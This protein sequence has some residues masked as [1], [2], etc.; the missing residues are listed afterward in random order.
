MAQMLSNKEIAYKTEV[1]TTTFINKILSLDGYGPDFKT[2]KGLFCSDFAT[3]T[4]H[5]KTTKKYERQAAK[6]NN[7]LL[8]QEYIAR[9][10][11]VKD[12]GKVEVTGKFIGSKKTET[13]RVSK[14]LKTG[15]FGGQ[16]GIKK[17]NLGIVFEK[18]FFKRLQECLAG[19][20]MLDP[21]TK[22]GLHDYST[23]VKYILAKTSGNELGGQNSPPR[24][25]DAVEDTGSKNTSRPIKASP[26]K[27]YIRPNAPL[28]H[29]TLLADVKVHHI[30]GTSN[31]SLKYG[32]TLTFMNA[33]VM[34]IFKEAEMKKKNITTQK[35]KNI[36]A[37]FGIDEATF[38][39]VFNEYGKKSFKDKHAT[40]T[41]TG[42]QQKLLINLLS[43]GIGADYWM[44]HGQP[45]K[46]VNFY[47]MDKTKNEK[48][49]EAPKDVQVK[50]GGAGGR[51]KRVDVEFSNTSFDFSLNIRNKQ[52]G[53]YPSHIMLDYTTKTIEGKTN[54]TNFSNPDEF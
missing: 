26:Q 21:L 28:K 14:F 40:V 39:D 49:S 10:P 46:S 13:L 50:Y 38:C 11:F 43:T 23:A 37:A 1:K 30:S 8:V 48:A 33:G 17:K 45:D 44:V 9:G 52:S 19:I 42:K 4:Y 20:Q 51:A 25:K 31:L 5:D 41:L 12:G 34:Q 47:Y 16:D 15:E 36:L 29:G 18:D 22:K 24:A 3:V 32:T 27:L 6:K 53:V 2:E 54:I 35:G 7:E